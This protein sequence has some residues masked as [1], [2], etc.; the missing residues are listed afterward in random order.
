METKLIAPYKGLIAKMPKGFTA[1]RGGKAYVFNGLKSLSCAADTSLPIIVFPMPSAEDGVYENETA[2]K[3]IK[4]EMV[5]VPEYEGEWA[6][7]DAVIKYASDVFEQP[8]LCSGSMETF[9]K[10]KTLSTLCG[11]DDLRPALQHVYFGVSEICATDANVLG[12]EQHDLWFEDDGFFILKGNAINTI[13]FLAKDNDIVSVYKSSE[14]TGVKVGEYHVFCKNFD[15]TYP[16]YRSVFPE[17]ENAFW[18]VNRKGL[19]DT[20]SVVAK[21][22]WE[23]KV[24]ICLESTDKMALVFNSADDTKPCVLKKTAVKVFEKSENRPGKDIRFVVFDAFLM[25]KILKTLS[26]DFVKIEISS[27]TR[28]IT[29][30]DTHLLMPLISKTNREKLL[31]G[32]P[33]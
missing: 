18:K 5:S 9:K 24:G 10:A 26:D 8:L 14:Y 6:N 28:A 20:L 19:I 27:E 17:S 21:R 13:A 29:I 3:A 7:A 22:K 32:E 15:T 25:A 30:D 33:F 1:V 12:V 31:S 16:D 11:V 2:L 23:C 4:L